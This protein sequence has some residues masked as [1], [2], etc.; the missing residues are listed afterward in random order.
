MLSSYFSVLG[1]D[2]PFLNGLRRGKHSVGWSVFRADDFGF[3]ADSVGGTFEF[4]F[5]FVKLSFTYNAGVFQYM[6]MM[7]QLYIKESLFMYC[8]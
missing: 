1:D 7:L 3:G 4:R 8:L 6:P 5:L 2:R